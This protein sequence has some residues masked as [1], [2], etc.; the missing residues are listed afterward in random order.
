[1]ASTDLGNMS[2]KESILSTANG[3]P[4]TFELEECD[5]ADDDG[6]RR[7]LDSQ[8]TLC[9]IC[10]AS[11]N[12]IPETPDLPPDPELPMPWF[13]GQCREH[14][15]AGPESAEEAELDSHF[16]LPEHLARRIA[17]LRRFLIQADAYLP[18]DLKGNH[19]K[20]HF[21]RTT[22][23]AKYVHRLAVL[24]AES[25]VAPLRSA[26]SGF[27]PSRRSFGGHTTACICPKVWGEK[28]H[29][30]HLAE[31]TC[32]GAEGTFSPSNN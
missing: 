20:Q 15:D 29:R 16:D 23:G 3:G 4:S 2:S 10:A 31:P 7:F 19:E 14:I 17:E 12:E 11:L 6:L 8:A 30:C 24:L 27:L 13:S 1:M 28:W 26:P 18:D 5:L 25:R 22:H 32:Y 9:R 21:R